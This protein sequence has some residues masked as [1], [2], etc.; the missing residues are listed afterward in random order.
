MNSTNPYRLL[1]IALLILAGGVS[2]LSFVPRS[3]LPCLDKR[4]SVQVHIVLDSLGEANITETDIEE[5]FNSING[6]FDDICVSFEVCDFNY[7][8][9]FQ[10]DT[11]EEAGNYQWNQMLDAH[12]QDFRINVFYIEFIEDGAAGFAGLGA[13]NVTDGNGICMTK[14]GGAGTLLHEMGHYWGLEHTF[15]T[16]NGAELA[17]GS[18]CATAGDLICDTPAD[19]YVDPGESSDYETNC[20]FVSQLTDANGDF[21]D[22]DVGNIMSYYDC[23][24]HF[25]YDQYNAMADLYSNNVVLSGEYMW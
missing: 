16:D 24:C 20:I 23:A 2:L 17:D 6:D 7:I 18:N 8:E 10:W 11:M 5:Q 22:P 9:N 3:E 12:H 14:A 19:P 1:A 21:Y 25:S 15:S 4:F 13:I